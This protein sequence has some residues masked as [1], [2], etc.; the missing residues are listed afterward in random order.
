MRARMRRGNSH[1]RASRMRIQLKGSSHP[2][3]KAPKTNHPT[4]R[5]ALASVINSLV[6]VLRGIAGRAKLIANQPQRNIPRPAS[7]PSRASVADGRDKCVGCA[8]EGSR[9]GRRSRQTPRRKFQSSHSLL[10]D[11]QFPRPPPRSL[12]PA[13]THHGNSAR[14]PVARAPLLRYVSGNS[15]DSKTVGSRS[16]FNRELPHRPRPLG[17]LATSKS[18]VPDAQHVRRPRAA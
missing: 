12:I 15:H 11:A 2:S 18:S 5:A 16:A 17:R 14:R 7:L 10:R 13:P 9:T 4:R 1:Q 8:P 3:D 6:S